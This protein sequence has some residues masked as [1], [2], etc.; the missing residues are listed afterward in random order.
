M[1]A[2]PEK[3]PRAYPLTAVM[4]TLGRESLKGTIAR[5]NRGTIAP[6]EIL[7]CI[8]EEDAHRVE[9]LAFPNVKVVR[10]KCRGQVAQRA[11]GFQ[12]AGHELVLQL[13][14]DIHVRETCLEYM[15]KH[16]E[17]SPDLAVAP[18][19]FDMK[20][21]TYFSYMIPE[22]GMSRWYRRL[23]FWVING[24]AGYQP[25]QIG[26][27]GINMGLP[28]VPEDWEGLGWLSGGCVLHHR[29]NLVLH[30]YYPFKGKAYSEDLFHSALLRKKGVNLARCGA[31]IC[32][33]DFS[34][35][36]ARS[37]VKFIKLYRAYTKT[38]TRFVRDTGGSRTRLYLFLIL[39]ITHL[40]A[41]KTVFSRQGGEAS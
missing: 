22:P 32:D 8:P 10:T 28:E 24:P 33:V 30:D 18:K 13:D 41:I 21:G 2:T 20:T 15:V 29:K 31:A 9:D 36:Y 38:M 16:I 17:R 5:L 26:R 12:H 7:I 14:D 34:S 1:T 19:M 11:V 37:P 23:L 35:S 3:G 4:A 25:G 6:A 27:A 40:V 39:N